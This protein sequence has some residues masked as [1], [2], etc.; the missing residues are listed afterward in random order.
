MKYHW[1][2]NIY[3]MHELMKLASGR[4]AGHLEFLNKNSGGLSDCLTVDNMR[5]LYPVAK[6]YLLNICFGINKQGEDMKTHLY[7]MALAGVL[8]MHGAS[9]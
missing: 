9:V 4:I 6:N 7:W 3:S 1:M 2:K 8:T 5:W